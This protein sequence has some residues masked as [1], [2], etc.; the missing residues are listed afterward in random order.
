[1]AECSMAELEER[2]SWEKCLV[3]GLLGGKDASCPEWLNF[4]GDRPSVNAST[5]VW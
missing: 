3:G 1:M 4:F 5:R 2:L